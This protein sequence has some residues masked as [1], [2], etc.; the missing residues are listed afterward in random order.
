MSFTLCRTLHAFLVFQWSTDH[1][2]LYDSNYCT[3]R[4]CCESLHSCATSH[5]HYLYFCPSWYTSASPLHTQTIYKYTTGKSIGLQFL[6]RTILAYRTSCI[7]IIVGN[8][9]LPCCSVIKTFQNAG[10]ILWRVKGSRQG[11]F[12]HRGKYTPFVRA[13]VTVFQPA[14]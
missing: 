12:T 8:I 6:K 9:M 3:T 2:R 14:Y 5:C 10:F 1:S 13:T 4:H 7:L 11:I